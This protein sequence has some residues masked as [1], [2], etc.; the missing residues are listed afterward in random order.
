[1]KAL[2][3]PCTLGI[4]LVVGFVIAAV[5]CLPGRAHEDFR[6]FP[7]SAYGA[8]GDGQHDDTSAIQSP[9]N[10]CAAAGGGT[11]LLASGTYVSGPLYLKSNVNFDVQ[12]QAVLQ[13]S[14]DHAE[15]GE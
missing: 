1:M 5:P 2:R 11:V 12:P 6:N 7:V 4:R 15:F 13:A 14:S 9:I 8:I 3:L 10:A